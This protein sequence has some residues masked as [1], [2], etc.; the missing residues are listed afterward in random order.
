MRRSRQDGGSDAPAA[1]ARMYGL[2]VGQYLPP[3]RGELGKWR[4][5]NAAGS[6][7]TWTDTRGFVAG[8]YERFEDDVGAKIVSR[9]PKNAR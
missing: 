5:Y 8:C 7:Q 6:G 1:D 3:V 4:A 9:E 2:G